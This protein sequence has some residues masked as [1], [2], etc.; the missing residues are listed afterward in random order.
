V[1]WSRCTWAADEKERWWA[2]VGVLMKGRVASRLMKER[3]G[4]L[5]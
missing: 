3:D 5:E 4:G 1:G 2:G